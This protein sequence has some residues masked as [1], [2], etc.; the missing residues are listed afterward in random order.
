MSLS[1]AELEQ[2]VAEL[3]PLVGGP[4]Q[5]AFAPSERLALLEV[6]VPGRSH[7]LLL[8]AEPE[9]ARLLI[10][11]TR[12]PSPADAL[13]FQH[14]VRQHLLARKLI[15]LSLDAATR[16]VR[17]EFEDLQ[18]RRVL[19]AELHPRQGN[20]VIL[21][22]TG[23]VV[24]AA[25]MVQARSRGL[26][27]GKPY[28][29]PSP[30]PVDGAPSRFVGGGDFALSAAIEAHYATAARP[31]LDHDLRARVERP[32]RTRLQR[33]VRTREKVVAE[34]S[35]VE[36]VAAF[37]AAGELLKGQLHLVRRGASNVKL[38]DWSSGEALEVEIALRPELSPHDN[39]ARLFHQAKRLEQGAGIAR[40][41]LAQLDDELAYVKA[42]LVRV[43]TLTPEALE[44][45][46]PLAASAAPRKK[47]PQRRQPFRLFE[48]H[49]G[50]R[51]LVGKGAAE[52]SELSFRLARPQDLWLHARGR[53]GAHVVVP[54]ERN[55]TV[56]PE[57]LLDACALAVH[58]SEAKG[59]SPVE[60]SHLLAKYLRRPRDGAPGQVLYAQEKTLRFVHDGP[61]L[62]RL[63]A[64]RKD[65]QGG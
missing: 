6:R 31:K 51:L 7:L 41:R 42:E 36:Q 37:R 8:S 47:G 26:A 46:A 11:T 1:S 33:L 52:N 30:M 32:L 39:L 44:A 14:A 22:P 24:G 62:A 10:A 16:T 9:R 54:L 23:L 53:T 61:R 4:V 64:S 55:E 17:L 57:L 21:G 45:E 43:A 65:E 34:A 12:P 2:V 3:L 38:T 48:G 63:L 5:K 19:M 29:P 59:E 15:G 20:L 58:F 18:G 56:P 49:G 13:P 27:V 40:E 25:S 35:R 50:R 28:L 60:V